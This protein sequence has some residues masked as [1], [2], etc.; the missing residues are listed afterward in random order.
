M[1]A[2][3]IAYI[4]TALAT[5]YSVTGIIQTTVGCSFGYI[6]KRIAGE[7]PYLSGM[8]VGAMAAWVLVGYLWR[9]FEGGHIPI[10]ALGM[11]WGLLLLARVIGGKQ[12]NY[13]AHLEMSAE[14]W[15]IAAIGGYVILTSDVVRWY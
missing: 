13:G 7:F 4:L 15:V 2:T 12:L 14:S 10:A 11:A 8:A 1:T 3:I 5:Y 9:T 6:V